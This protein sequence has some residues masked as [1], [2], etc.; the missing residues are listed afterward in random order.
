[1][2]IL[3]R[4]FKQK[5]YENA[6]HWR[7]GWENSK[8]F[9]EVVFTTIESVVILAAMDIA[10]KKE[11]SWV[12]AVIN[13]LAFLALLSYLQTYFRYLI[14]ATNEKFEVIENPDAFAWLAGIAAMAISL[15][16]T[17]LLPGMISSF[18]SANFMQ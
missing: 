13:G 1:M 18:V 8:T 2:T 15:G 12:L 6:V 7:H 9:H 17:F 16:I 5:D 10:L 14:N 11:W 3:T 4:I